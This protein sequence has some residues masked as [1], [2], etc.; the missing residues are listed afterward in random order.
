MIGP[1]RAF[2]ELA[3]LSDG[4]LSALAAR[5]QVERRPASTILLREGDASD[6]RLWL[7]LDGQVDVAAHRP[8]GGFAVAYR[9]SAPSVLGELGLLDGGPRSATCTAA[10]AVTLGVLT[11]DQL[12]TLETQQPRAREAL[13]HLLARVMV[14][15]LR[16]LQAVL[17]DALRGA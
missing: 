2:P 3:L 15:R 7:L 9:L 12:D 17:E 6:D 1:L 10:T 4:E 8:D 16:G 13:E 14:R 5:V 11:R